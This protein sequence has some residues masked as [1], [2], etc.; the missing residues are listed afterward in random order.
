MHSEAK[1]TEMLA[2]GSEN[3]LL[4]DHEGRRVAHA[5]QI[6]PTPQTN[7]AKHFSRQGEVGAYGWLL[8]TSWFQKSFVVVAVHK[9][10]VAV[11]L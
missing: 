10:Q 6:S 8:Q 1:Q 3:G 7:I 11:F 5:P 2:F 9:G 4:Q